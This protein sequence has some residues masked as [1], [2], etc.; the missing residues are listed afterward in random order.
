VVAGGVRWWLGFAGKDGNEEEKGD[1]EEDEN[2]KHDATINER[3]YRPLETYR[4]MME[5]A[6]KQ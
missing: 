5:I 3:N 1:E 4:K 6:P 2:W